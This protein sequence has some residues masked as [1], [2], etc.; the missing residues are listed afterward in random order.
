MPVAD[1]N[2]TAMIMKIKDIR[3]SPD[4]ASHTP[5]QEYAPFQCLFH[6][7]MKM[8]RV[9]PLKHK[10]QQPVSLEALGDRTES[11]SEID[12]RSYGLIT[13]ANSH[14]LRLPPGMS[15]MGQLLT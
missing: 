4:S 13:I 8:L 12:A 14:P 15:A 3:P 7:P 6:A 9:W 10:A 11:C 1:K 2:G 5:Q